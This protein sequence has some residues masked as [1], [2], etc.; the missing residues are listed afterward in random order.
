M[1]IIF[2]KP[3]D[4]KKGIIIF[5]H[6]EVSLLL[7][8]PSILKDFKNKYIAIVHVGHY[9]KRNDWCCFFDGVIGADGVFETNPLNFLP[10]SSRDYVSVANENQ[11]IYDLIFIGSPTHHKNI[12]ILYDILAELDE[13][14][15]QSISVLLIIPY[16]STIA[17]THEHY[18]QKIQRKKWSNIAIDLIRSPRTNSLYP[19]KSALIIEL[20]QKSRFLLHTSVQEGESRV[21]E[22][23][24][25]LGVHVF[26]NKELR[27]GGGRNLS[28]SQITYYDNSFEILNKICEG[29][30]VSSN[31]ID[32]W[33][34]DYRD[35]FQRINSLTGD[36]SNNFVINNG[37]EWALPSQIKPVYDVDSDSLTSDISSVLKL[38]KFAQYAGVNNHA[39][40]TPG[41]FVFDFYFS[42]FSTV[43]GIVSYVVRRW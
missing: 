15:L 9:Q 36:A 17:A 18:V 30:Q 39:Q 7:R 40:M 29:I 10:I 31:K 41:N 23:A 35:L 26:A 37:L 19:L 32:P 25:R 8:F 21:I 14:K 24:A 33:I 4:E 16:I 5:T 43:K 11:K 28:T 42:V 1:A 34:D 38:R 22:E 12:D 13:S 2:T 6:K 20:I 27:G 3:L